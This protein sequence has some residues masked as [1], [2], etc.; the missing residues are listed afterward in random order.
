LNTQ[1]AVTNSTS[2][3]LPAQNSSVAFSTWLDARR[4]EREMEREIDRLRAMLRNRDQEY[5]EAIRSILSLE[6]GAAG[7]SALARTGARVDTAVVRDEGVNVGVEGSAEGGSGAGQSHTPASLPDIST[8]ASSVDTAPS[9]RAQAVNDVTNTAYSSREDSTFSN[10][11]QSSQ[12]VHDGDLVYSARDSNNVNNTANSSQPHGRGG[13]WRANN[14]PVPPSV[15][16]PSST[17]SN[18]SELAAS[19]FA[20]TDD[21]S[22]GTPSTVVGSE[23]ESTETGI[24]TATTGMGGSR[25][26]DGDGD[27]DRLTV[28]CSSNSQSGSREGDDVPDSNT[29]ASSSAY[30]DVGSPR[31]SVGVFQSNRH[32]GSSSLDSNADTN[33]SSGTCTDTCTKSSSQS[34]LAALANS[35]LDHAHAHA[36]LIVIDGTRGSIEKVGKEIVEEGDVVEGGKETETAHVGC[37]IE[38]D[39]ESLSSGSISAETIDAYIKLKDPSG[40][41][42]GNGSKLESG[43]LMRAMTE[44]SEESKSQKGIMMEVAMQQRA[45]VQPLYGTVAAPKVPLNDGRQVPSTQCY[46]EASAPSS[47]SSSSS[48]SFTGQITSSTTA[49][50]DGTQHSSSS[51]LDP[52]SAYI[53]SDVTELLSGAKHDENIFQQIPEPSSSS[54]EMLLLSSKLLKSK[55]RGEVECRSGGDEDVVEE[56]V[57]EG[58]NE[59]SFEREREKHSVPSDDVGPPIVRSVSW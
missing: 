53:D 50:M 18:I 3:P 9:I 32:L 52:S 4:E 6:G 20:D 41:G 49:L 58:K 11:S 27:G 28:E 26:G 44:A 56:K 33:N 25:D 14:T 29:Q 40:K 17:A 22:M 13:I 19:E 10:A 57:E 55:V 36:N 54:S 34:D 30:S 16:Q 39:F 47:S 23:S 45:A 15:I 42:K 37:Y 24:A 5:E 31:S 38:K 12:E 43:Q 48:P 51:T 35:R 46:P 1:E 59:E 7:T 2:E 21:T 8:M